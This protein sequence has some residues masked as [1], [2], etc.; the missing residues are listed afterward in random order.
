MAPAKTSWE[1][2]HRTTFT[3]QPEVKSG[4]HE[5]NPMR[6]SSSSPQWLSGNMTTMVGQWESSQVFMLPIFLLINYM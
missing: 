5:G 6:P 2:R 3:V 4:S 1:N